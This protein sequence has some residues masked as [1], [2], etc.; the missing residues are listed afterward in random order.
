[1]DLIKLKPIGIIHTKF[2]NKINT[3]IQPK[4]SKTKAIV[5]VFPEYKQGLKDLDGFSHIILI[6]YFH[7]SNGYNLL[8]RPYLDENKR[9]LFSTRGPNRPNNIGISTVTLEK[10]KDNILYVKGVDIIDKSPLLDIK[11][12]I[13]EFKNSEKIKSGWIKGKVTKDHKADDRF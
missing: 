13:K 4:F 5:E 6:Y 7:K 3:P 1:M 9:G 12:Y 11:P 8:V 2:K 10:I